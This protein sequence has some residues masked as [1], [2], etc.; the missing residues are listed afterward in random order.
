VSMMEAV[1]DF[2][3]E[4]LTCYFND[5]R[6]LP[7]RSQVSNGNAYIPAPYG[8]YKTREGYLSL[9]MG[10]IPKLA[11]LLQCPPLEQYTDSAQ[12]F[13]RR[14]EIKGILAGHLLNQTADEWLSV[15]QPADIWCAKVMDYHDLMQQIGYKVLNMELKVKTSNGLSIRTTR[16]PIRVDGAIATS[17]LGAP[18]LGE[19]NELIDEQFGLDIVS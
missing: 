19:H 3:F 2:Q 18:L 16:C 7:E 12:W 17:E 10:D 1:L 13:E 8:I 4:V 9:A 11:R 15:L 14:D 5:G 6:Q